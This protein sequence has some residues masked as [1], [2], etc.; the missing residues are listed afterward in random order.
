VAGLMGIWGCGGPK[1]HLIDDPR[2]LFDQGMDDFQKEK[3]PSAVEKF[4]RL[5]YNFPGAIFIDSAQFFLAQSYFGNEEYEL[6]AV[7]YNRLVS[8]YPQSQ[9][10]DDAQ[11]MTG[12]CYFKGTPKHFGLDQEDLKLAVVAMENFILDNPDSELVPDARQVILE[13]RTKLARKDYE[14]GILYTKMYDLRAARIYFQL[15][16][17]EYTDTQYGG[18]ALYRLAEIDYKEKDYQTA[19]DRLNQFLN[20]YENSELAEKARGLLEEI[21]LKTIKAQASDDE[22]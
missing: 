17:D 4:Q 19:S 2:V 18:M 3:Y 15:V 7:E 13:A 8:N 21:S 14:S 6:A 22:P 20:I 11:Y 1:T 5:V 16:I 12:L 9:L 10:Y